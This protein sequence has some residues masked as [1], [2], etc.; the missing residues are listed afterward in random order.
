MSKFPQSYGD[1]LSVEQY[2]SFKHHELAEFTRDLHIVLY[3]QT[4]F[5]KW[6]QIEL[7]FAI[8]LLG[9]WCMFLLLVIV[10]SRTNAFNKAF[11][12]IQ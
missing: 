9:V 7:R 1:V 6:Q 10:L 8:L 3:Q 12:W 2:E 5:A 4:D 11:K